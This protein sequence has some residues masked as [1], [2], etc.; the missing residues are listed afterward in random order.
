MD[1][2]LELDSVME[3]ILDQLSK[4]SEAPQE[5][6]ITQHLAPQCMSNSAT[7]SMSNSV[8]LSMSS[9]AGEAQ[10]IEK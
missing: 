2:V 8:L 3:Q 5:A 7:R 6:D 9:N 1:Q 4:I 10:K